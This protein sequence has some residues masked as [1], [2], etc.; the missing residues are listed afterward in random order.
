MHRE[1][2]ENEAE[3]GRV[4]RLPDALVDQ[5][6]AGEVVERPASV[7]KELVENALDAGSRRVRVEIRGGGRDWIAVTDDGR[8]MSPEDARLALQRHA[9]SKIGTLEDLQT[10]RT[11]GFRGEALPAIASVSRLRVRTRPQGSP[12]AWE[13]R[14]DAGHLIDEREAGGPEGTRIEVADLF[15][16][17]PARRKFLKTPATEWGHSAD[18]LARAALALPGVHFD[19]RR[20]DRPALVWP[21]TNEPLDRVASVVSEADAAAFVPVER[22]EGAASLQGFVSRPDHHR[23]TL[24]GV[25]LFV[26]QRPVRDRVLQHALVEVYRDLL[27]RG[28]FPSAVIFLD[29]PPDAV[30]VNVHPAKWEVRFSDPRFMHRL[31]SQ[32]VRGAIESRSWLPGAG[33]HA[34]GESPAGGLDSG[35]S[36]LQSPI[37]SRNL[38]PFPTACRTH[39]GHG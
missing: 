28:R 13:L 24:A 20:D 32:A 9:T 38:T 30:D 12:L 34:A 4:R 17:I 35:N 18:W 10:I 39:T 3:H 29:V 6:A 7:V 26:N 2:T 31:V 27:P 25:Y 33:A 21:S 37:L 5:I 22:H 11:Y 16:A 36:R 23:P 1:N 19:I 14:V 15:S 8:G